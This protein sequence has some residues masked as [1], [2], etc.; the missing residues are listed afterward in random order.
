MTLTLWL[1]M[2]MDDRSLANHCNP[3]LK[4]GVYVKSY[5]SLYTAL[6]KFGQDEGNQI[7]RNDYAQG[8]TLFA[9]N[10]TPHLDSDDHFTPVRSGPLSLEI[11]FALP[12]TINVIILAEFENTIEVN[13]S[14]NILF[15]YT[16]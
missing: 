12:N 2:C 9:F 15:D 7:S 11:H 16:P 8:Y 14:Q 4:K 3:T 5:Q 6:N 10:L 1:S 13:K